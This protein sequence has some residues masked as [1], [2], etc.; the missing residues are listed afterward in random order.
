ML[1]LDFT[2]HIAAVLAALAFSVTST[3]FTLSGRRLGPSLVVQGSLPLGLVC[4]FVLHWVTTG[5]SFPGDAG[6]G[7]WLLFGISGVI[8]FWLGSLAVVNAII[9]LGPRLALLVLAIAPILSAVLAWLFLDETLDGQAIAGIIVTITGIIWVVSEGN[10]SPDPV[11]RS[12]YRAGILFALAG[13][14]SQSISFLF[15]KQGLAGDFDPLSASLM[16]LMTGTVAIWLF[17]ALRGRVR[18]DLTALR[19]YPVALRQLS[20]GAIAGPVTGASLML[21]A[22]QH[23]PV[24]IATTLGNLT[25]IFLIPIGYV[26]FKE[27][28]THRA[29]TGTL[30]AMVGMAILFI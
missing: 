20:L 26:V 25:P 5:Q 2:G 8:G 6:A 15:S 7:R 29:I 24:G 14:L 16:R 12:A 3:F 30:V 4:I 21:L 17:A 22:L 9:R 18:R 10:Q 1:R 19:T 28:I 13:A 11:D 27:R 23:A